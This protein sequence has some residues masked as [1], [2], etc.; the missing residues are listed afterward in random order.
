MRKLLDIAKT[1]LKLGTISFGG[2]AAHIDLMETEAVTRRRWLSREHFLDLFAATNLIPGPNAV[3]MA[4]HIGYR[5]AGLIGSLVAGLSFSLPAV[6]ISAALAVSY[7][8]YGQ[9]PY[10]APLL[11]G[12]KP[13]VLAIILAAL[14]RLGRKA[15]KSVTLGLIGSGVAVAV[16]RFEVDEVLALLTGSLIGAL[17][18]RPRKSSGDSGAA[19]TAGAAGA[20]LLAGTARCAQAQTAS[21]ASIAAPLAAAGAATLP[22]WKLGLFFFKVGLVLYGGGYVL[23]AYLEGGLVDTY[24]C[25]TQKQLLD[26]VAVG[27]FTPGPMLSTATFVGYLVAGVPGAAVATV[28]ILLPCF[29]FVAAVNPLIPRLRRSPLASRFLDAVTAASLGLMASVTLTLGHATLLE[30]SP[31]WPGWLIFL[32][33]SAIGLRWKIPPAYLVAAGAL[34]GGLVYWLSP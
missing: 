3:E 12:V 29:L 22:L 11:L 13:A 25:L 1:F 16:L 14:W 27:Q 24:E 18:L 28:G 6:L 17:L 15:L 30:V 32:T 31:R 21:A 19:K 7:K 34:A 23:V 2:P 20:T 33:A 5:R 10:V 26:A 4:N 8:Q 9:S